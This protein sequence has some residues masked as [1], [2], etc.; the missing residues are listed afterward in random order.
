M[1]EILKDSKVVCGINSLGLAEARILGIPCFIPVFDEISEYKDRFYF[2]KYFGNELTP[3]KNQIELYAEIEKKINSK[4]KKI[5]LKI[6]KSLSKNILVTMMVK[7]PK[8]IL[9]FY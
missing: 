4:F 6:I 2:Q 9:T 7:I 1:G 5:I 3:I 8:D